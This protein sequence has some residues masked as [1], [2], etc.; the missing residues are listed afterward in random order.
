MIDSIF[1]M[2]FEG[3]VDPHATTLTVITTLQRTNAPN[4]VVRIL[5]NDC[6]FEKTNTMQR[7]LT[8]AK[9]AE[10]VNWNKLRKTPKINKSNNRRIHLID[11]YQLRRNS[12]TIRITWIISQI[13]VCFPCLSLCLN[14]CLILCLI[15]I[16]LLLISLVLRIPSSLQ[17]MLDRFQ[18]DHHH[19]WRMLFL[20]TLVWFEAR[21][22]DQINA[23]TSQLSRN[24][25]QSVINLLTPLALARFKSKLLLILHQQLQLVVLAK[26]NQSP[27]WFHPWLISQDWHLRLVKLTLSSKCVLNNF[28]NCMHISD[29]FGMCHILPI[30]HA[31]NI[32]TRGYQKSSNPPSKS[33]SNSKES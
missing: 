15:V 5:L 33:N 2:W 32:M 29:H 24:L 10:Y 31:E 12:K 26:S 19:L 20:C 13:S 1:E 28:L 11:W 9:K 21:D 8:F 27:F 3:R 4:D 25:N 30:F 18:K 6:S 14:L 22:G 17:P 16:C 7:L 23:R